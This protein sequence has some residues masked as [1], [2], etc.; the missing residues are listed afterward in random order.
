MKLAL[1]SFD[2]LDPRVIYDHPDELPNLHSLMDESIHG[3]WRTPGHTI[4]SYITT[5][6]G[7]PTSTTKFRW[8]E[9]EGGFARHRQVEREFLWEAVN[10]SMTLLNI[11]VIYPPEEIDDCMV[12]GM[13]CPDELAKN[14]LATPSSAQ[15]ILN[16][17]GYI[18]EVRA[19]KV[20]DEVGA[21]G[22]WD[23]LS[24][25]MV[26]RT[27]AANRLIRQFD[28]ELFYGVWTAPD[29]WFHRHQTHGVDYF[30]MYERADEELDSIL[31]IIP[32]GVP[33][34]VFSDHGFAHFKRDEP[35]TMGHMY[36]GFYCIRHPDLPSYRDDT[37]NIEDLFPTVVNYLGGE[38][39]DNGRGRILFHREDQ[40]ESVQS[41]LRD[42]GY[43]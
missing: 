27:T 9:G 31:D 25:S 10:A 28:S 38:P 36:E 13:L 43:L 11:P 32:D 24:E 5:L 26:T 8:D 12:A 34:V 18:H 7:L 19:D 6:T 41:R 23:L 4:P 20:F 14:N 16:D 37:A 1:V 40:D 22:M 35:A 15:E 42:L 39:P 3:F 21:Q 2:G 30:Q 33:L 17:I 29:R